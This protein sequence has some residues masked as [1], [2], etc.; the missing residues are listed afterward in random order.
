MENNRQSA[1]T[2]LADSRRAALRLLI[3]AFVFLLPFWAAVVLYL[4]DDPYMSLHRY[5]VYD[6]PVVL[7]ENFV[8]WGIYCNHRHGPHAFNSFIMGNSCTMAYRCAEWER[9]LPH[10]AHAMRLFGNAESLAGLDMKLHAMERDHAR[11]DNVLIVLDASSLGDDRQRDGWEHI[12]P[13]EVSGKSNLLTQVQMMRTFI[14]PDF[15]L[16]Y[17]KYKLTGQISSSAK[18]MNPYGR[19]RNP[20]N[21]DSYNP[22]ER[23]IARQ[24]E[25]YWQGLDAKKLPTRTHRQVVGPVYIFAPQAR[26][27]LDIAALLK[28]H[29]TNYRIVISP[30]YKQ[31]A[32]NPK[33]RESLYVIFG[34]KN[35]FDFTGVNRFTADYHD[36]YEAAHYRPRLGDRVMRAVY[37]P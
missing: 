28:R 8:G 17:L 23:M 33:D 7:N 26:K 14:L 20:E 5:R 31:V 25:A 37:R 29:H 13:P 16:P 32:M 27:L 3:K 4:H 12:L 35:V 22:R 15:L 34:R 11:I 10:G 2:P 24:G 9:Y 18:C 19:I 1:A 21:N 36:Y 30:D 6:S